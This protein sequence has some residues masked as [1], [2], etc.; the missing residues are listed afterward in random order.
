MRAFIAI[1]LPE[2]IK[3]TLGEIQGRLKSGLDP[4]SWVKPQNLHLTLKFLGEISEEQMAS[5]DQII[6]AQAK[7]TAA[8]KIKLDDLG[9]F[10]NLHQARILWIGAKLCP[11]VIQLAANLENKIAALGIAKEERTFTSHIT[12]G[13]IKSR[14][15]AQNL[16]KK[17]SAIKN[18]KIFADL[19][20]TARG[21]ALFQST[22]RESG[23]VYTVLKE[24][25]FKTA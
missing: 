24:A 23:P 15:P 16:E 13:R 1:D 14:I 20:F 8:F 25:S 17:F 22:L 4:I 19:E 12:L 21:L 7:I 10:P 18:E 6:T 2:N 9:V 5:T 3:N 11:P